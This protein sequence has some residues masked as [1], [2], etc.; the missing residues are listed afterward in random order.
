[1]KA[2]TALPIALALMGSA[3]FGAEPAHNWSGPYIGASAGYAWG[4]VSATDDL[5]DWCTAGDTACIAKYVGPF[6]FDASGV[7]GALRGGYLMQ[8][9]G[10]VLGPEIEAGYLD[11][12]G[13]KVIS[14]SVGS[15]KYQTLN[16]DG[17]W[18]A[19][20][21]GR[22]GIA[23]GRTFVYGRG[24]WIYWDTDLTQTT[25]NPGYKTNGTGAVN[26]WAYGGG[27]EH[28]L[29][30]GWSLRADYVHMDFGANSGDQTSVSDAPI[31][32]VYENHFDLDADAVSVGATYSFG[33]SE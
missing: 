23:F 16:V 12:T 2:L 19:M 8:F 22:A 28:Y 32:H 30:N 13:D 21:G 17:G 14:S 25:T 3:A 20:L 33:G 6:D 10:L 1:M 27:L 9:Q 5:N 15:P 24:G 31:G 18:Y 4:N 29:G 11:L 7:S 26:G